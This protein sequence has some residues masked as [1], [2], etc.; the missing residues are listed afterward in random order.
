MSTTP[1]RTS[2]PS[3]ST[4]VFIPRLRPLSIAIGSCHV[5]PWS[6]SLRTGGAAEQHFARR[7]SA[8]GNFWHQNLRHDCPKRARERGPYLRAAIRR[9]TRRS[10]ARSRPGAVGAEI[11]PKHET[12]GARRV[13]RGDERFRR[14]QI[15]NHEDVGTLA[16][17]RARRLAIASPSPRTSRWLMKDS[18]FSCTRWICD[19]MVIT[20]S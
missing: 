20:W 19:S 3:E 9:E 10:A 11:D 15:F 12:A 13:E 17:R 18:R 8:A 4:I 14:A 6:I 16:Q 1:S 7:D 5:A 2:A